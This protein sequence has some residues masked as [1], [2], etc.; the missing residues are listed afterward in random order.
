MHKLTNEAMVVS[1]C[2]A[3]Q[4][5][6]ETCCCRDGEAAIMDYIADGRRGKY[7]GIVQYGRCDFLNK[8]LKDAKDT[9]ELINYNE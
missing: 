6:P 7:Y 4:C 5:H 8:I 2:Q 3:R 9:N 1:S